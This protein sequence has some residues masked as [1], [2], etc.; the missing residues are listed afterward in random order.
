MESVRPE[1]AP[2]QRPGPTPWQFD[3]DQRRA[4]WA[5]IEARLD[6]SQPRPRPPNLR[7][8]TPEAHAQPRTPALNETWA[9][10][11][12]GTSAIL[13]RYPRAPRRGGKSICVKEEKGLASA[14]EG[15]ME[16]VGGI[17]SV[18]VGELARHGDHQAPQSMRSW[19]CGWGT[20]GRG[21]QKP[22]AWPRIECRIPGE[23][24]CKPQQPPETSVVIAEPGREGSILGRGRKWGA[25]RFFKKT[26]ARNE[27]ARHS[28][29]VLC[30]GNSAAR[31]A[32]GKNREAASFN[33]S[34]LH[35]RRLTAFNGW[36]L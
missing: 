4:G 17:R 21:T 23:S 30:D 7:N 28:G 27:G 1:Q 12:P 36:P 19:R 9:A 24:P 32:T 20:L 29:L 35:V 3:K 34:G 11:R 25:G 10:S 33:Q 22:R 5:L 16:A 26:I 15:V 14:R 18:D 13:A 8:G 2:G 6:C 31:Q